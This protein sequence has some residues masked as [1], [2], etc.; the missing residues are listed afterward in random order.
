MAGSHDES[1]PKKS[2]LEIDDNKSVIDLNFDCLKEIFKYLT[3][4]DLVHLAE[5]HFPDGL[6][7]V[8]KTT[9]FEECLQETFVKQQ[10]R[11]AIII[12]DPNVFYLQMLRHFGPLITQTD[13]YHSDNHKFE[14]QI[15]NAIINH[16]RTTLTGLTFYFV[17]SNVMDEIDQPFDNI[18]NVKFVGGRL[19]TKIGHFKNWFPRMKSLQILGVSIDDLQCVRKKFPLLEHFAVCNDL[20]GYELDLEQDRTDASSRLKYY[21]SPISN[22]DNLSLEAFIHLNPQL[23]S[24]CITHN[25]DYMVRDTIK[26]NSDLLKCIKENLPDL[27]SLSL[28]M[29]PGDSWHLREIVELNNLKKLEI[30]AFNDRIFDW[31]FTGEFGTETYIQAKNLQVLKL[32]GVLEDEPEYEFI[33]TFIANFPSIRQLE[34]AHFDDFDIA[35]EVMFNF[36]DHLEKIYVFHDNENDKELASHYLVSRI[37]RIAG[38]LGAGVRITQVK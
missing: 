2:N 8:N 37:G 6:A 32:S 22:F 19:G 25:D 15:E 11:N 18:Q 1:T 21:A 12:A 29:N 16:C 36:M 23:K 38:G 9:H 24:L 5:A 26:I 10:G 13:L 20:C 3:I 17:G 35:H 14:R 34:F 31:A 27:E 33:S 30:G 4:G 7:S 28:N